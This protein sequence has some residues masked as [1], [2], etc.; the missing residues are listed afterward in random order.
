MISYKDLSDNLFWDVNPSGLDFEKN[1]RQ[2][3]ERVITRGSLEDWYT[4]RDY[5]GVEKIKEEVIKIRSLDP[6]SISFWSLMFKVPEEKFKSYDLMLNNP[7]YKIWYWNYFT[8]K[9]AS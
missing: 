3:I 4:I 1:A 9:E 7:D 6:M 2:I 5:Y 8:P